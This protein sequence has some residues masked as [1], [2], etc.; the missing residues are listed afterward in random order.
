MKIKNVAKGLA[1]LLG[2]AA[3]ALGMS[4]DARGD[5]LKVYNQ[6]NSASEGISRLQ[7]R[8]GALEIADPGNSD[9]Y[10]TSKE[11]ELNNL[12]SGSLENY[13]YKNGFRLGIDARPF[14]SSTP[15][16]LK[17]VYN[18]TIPSGSPL[19]NHL[20]FEYGSQGSSSFGTSPLTLQTPIGSRY[21]IRS[22]IDGTL[23]GEL[24]PSLGIF[25]LPDLAAG[26]YDTGTPYASYQVDFQ[27]VNIPEPSS[28]VLAATGALA[29]GGFGIYNLLRRRKE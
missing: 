11:F 4:G 27:P 5:T 1:G 14:D 16:V 17:L 12:P 26:S 2:S 19:E 22:I 13:F 21:D 18:G 3:L 23:G 10:D 25:N 24:N 28:F 15:F 20:A 7:H 9:P 6:S 29:V 8:D